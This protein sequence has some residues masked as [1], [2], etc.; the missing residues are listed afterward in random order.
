MITLITAVPGSGKSLFAV[1]LVLKAV[2]EGRPVYSNIAG[3]QIPQCM[4]AP[5]DWRETM[6]GALVIY[7]EAQQQHLYP[8]TAHRGEVKDE[9]LRAMETHR[10]SG[11][12][13]VFI[14]QSPSFLHHHIRKLAGEHIH[15]Y[16][17]FGMK[18][19]TRYTWQHCVDSP[20][21]RSEQARADSVPWPFPKEHMKLYKSATIH[22]HKFK[23]PKK[24][25]AMCVLIA[26]VAVFTVYLASSNDDSFLFGPP[27]PAVASEAPVESL[28]EKA[29]ASVLGG[30]GSAATTNP[31][32]P[33]STSM[34]DWA[35]TE[36]ATSVAG[37]ISS[38]SKCQCY[39]SEGHM[40]KM[41]HAACLSAIANPLP[42]TII[43][44]TSSQGQQSVQPP[45]QSQAVA[46]R[47]GVPV[48]VV[49]SG[50]PGHLW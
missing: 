44:G 1:G 10:H 11:H 15:L 9:R 42:R 13:L 20:N 7:D 45:Q 3:L 41:N 4:P 32:R 36:T 50:K 39:S 19:V 8:S 33:A 31:K 26:L 14:S 47:S 29:A 37:C 38:K 30:V 40:L 49:N 5:D 18:T 25:A 21:D 2:E 46:Q 22:T 34:Y 48:T 27:G 23:L 28:P 16:R 43:V 12:D 6:E 24:L 17:A 35:D